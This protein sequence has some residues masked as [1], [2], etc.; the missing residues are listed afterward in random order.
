MK[1]M[2]KKDEISEIILIGMNHK[3]A[4]VEVRE[5]FYLDEQSIEDFQ[6]EALKKGIDEIVY[7]STCNRVEI[8]FAARHVHNAVQIILDLI[9]RYSGIQKENFTDCLY[10]KYSRDAVSHLLYV[11]SSLDSMVVGENEILMQIK[12]AYR[13]SVLKKHS[14]ILLNRMFHQAFNTAKKVKT[15][16]GISQNPLSIAYIATEQARAIFNNDFSTVRALLIGAGEMGELIVKYFTK[17][18]ISDITIANRSLQNAERIVEDVNKEAHV[19]PIEDLETVIPTVDIIITSVSSTDYI[20]TAPMIRGVAE[21]RGERPLFIIDIGVPRNVDPDVA[22]MA[23][24]H[25]Y[26]I[27]DLKQIS[28]ENLKNRLKEVEVAKQIVNDDATQLFEWYEGLDL[29]PMIQKIRET[30]DS[31]REQEFEK[32]SRRKLKHLSDEDMLLVEE[33]TKQIMS[34]I[35]HNPIVA[36]KQNKLLNKDGYHCRESIREKTKVIE[37]LFRQIK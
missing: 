2:N 3:S 4:P 23:N 36:I 13:D 16:T 24:V 25:L 6:N 26:N 10:K 17:N 20:L 28:E 32:Y 22:A 37:E 31:I 15:G 33:L 9:E 34:K 29:V 19:I 12:Q 11:A 5:Q 27:D 1:K 21:E 8:Y 35:L 30:F 7:L 18:N 14:G